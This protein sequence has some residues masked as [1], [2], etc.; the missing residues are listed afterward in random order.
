MLQKQLFRS[1]LLT[2][3]CLALS[4]Q[5]RVEA[6]R[7]TA[8]RG[9]LQN[10]YNYWFYEP[11]GQT[12][13]NAK[14][15]V[16]FLHGASL[17]GRDLSKVRRYGTLD[18]INRGLKLDAFVL[19]PQNPGGTWNPKRIN[20]I[21]D[22]ACDNY[23]I[24][25]TRI[26][27]IGMSLGGFGTLDYV[28]EYPQRVAAGMA[29]CGGA[30]TQKFANL[31]QVPMAIMHGTNDRAV[32]WQQSRDV[33]QRMRSAGDTTRLVYRLLPKRTH[34]DLARYFYLAD[35]YQ[36]LFEH[37]LSDE[38]RPVNRDYY[39]GYDILDNVY[40][41]M[42]KPDNPLTVVDA[43][44]TDKAK[45]GKDKT[46]TAKS[47]AAAET[48][49]TEDNATESGVHVVRK[50]DNLTR[51]AKRYNVTVRH[52]LQMNHLREESVLQIGQKIKY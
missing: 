40:R 5:G 11:G 38:G 41:K 24:D 10:A 52:L 42:E 17:C 30:T 1:C 12:G 13:E 21:V 3:L 6:Q 36:W 29:L 19:A 27:V 39:F 20:R 45:R 28:A 31:C 37:T 49:P 43:G 50:G 2:L 44:T 15:L 48:T 7:L 4:S 25:S 18:A 33:M 16:L 46:P 51:I 14:P 8:H 35:T 23:A 32:A 47:N 9:N 26:Y 34:G 22:W